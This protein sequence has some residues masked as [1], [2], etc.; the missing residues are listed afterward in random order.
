M[1]GG[2]IEQVG[3]PP[4]IYQRPLNTFVADF[5]GISNVLR[6]RVSACGGRL[7]TPDGELAV[8][9][10]APGQPGALVIRPEHIAIAAGGR[11]GL[12]GSVIETV[13]AGAETRLLVALAS[14]TVITVRRSGD[15]WSPEV[16]AAVAVTWEPDRAR[17]L[18]T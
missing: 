2:R 8:S 17:F 9:P 12:A 7:V 11:E 5:I 13:Y 16:G 15:Q 3:T 6:G 1:N 10:A 14:G 18:D 4:E